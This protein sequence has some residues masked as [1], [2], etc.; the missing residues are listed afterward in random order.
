MVKI[1]LE[2]KACL[3]NVKSLRSSGK[4]FRWFLKFR[5]SNCGEVTA[6]WQYVTEE[7][8]A[9]LKGGRGQA[10]LVEKC[11]M[12]ARDNSIS[13]IEDRVQPYTSEDHLKSKVVVGFECRGLEPIDF[14]LRSGWEVESNS[15]TKSFSDVDLKDH[16]W[17]EYDDIAN[18]SIS[19]TEFT[20]KFVKLKK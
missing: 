3:E 6:N 9:D 5:C 14:D 20:F 10:N 1:G 16:E 4:D 8:S 7:M 2:F 17:Y 19:I 11:K 15:S 18:E 12:C 13:I